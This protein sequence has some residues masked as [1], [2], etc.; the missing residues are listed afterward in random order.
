[1]I[2]GVDDSLCPMRSLRLGIVDFE[3]FA[4]H[5]GAA[6][7]VEARPLDFDCLSNGYC[8]TGIVGQDAEVH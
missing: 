4:E 6:H 2:A 1:M 3:R 8:W 5:D 7:G